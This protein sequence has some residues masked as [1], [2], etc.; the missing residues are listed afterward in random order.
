[1]KN[2]IRTVVLLANLVYL[3]T[4]LTYLPRFI[5]NRRSNAYTINVDIGMP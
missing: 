3:P 2:I 4:Y 5:D 1:M